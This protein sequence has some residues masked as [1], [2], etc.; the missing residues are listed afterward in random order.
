MWNMADNLGKS[1]L[2]RIVSRFRRPYRRVKTPTVIQM[3]AVECGAAA[4]KIILGYHGRIIP[5]EELREAC[6]VSRDGSKAS[7]MLKA[8]RRHGLVAKGLL[9]LVTL[10]HAESSHDRIESLRIRIH[11]AEQFIFIPLSLFRPVAEF[12]P[13]VVPAFFVG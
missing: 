5:L 11:Q 4:L 3:E 1:L 2:A 12:P 6:G 7:N 13:T 8:A 10:R 9:G